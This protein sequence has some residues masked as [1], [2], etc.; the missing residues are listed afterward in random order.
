[1]PEDWGVS[2]LHGRLW[3]LGEWQRGGTWVDLV[4][5]EKE[6]GRG[7]V[8]ERESKIRALWRRR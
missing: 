7:I 8:C 3:R 4:D 5:L 1:L 2:G 6:W